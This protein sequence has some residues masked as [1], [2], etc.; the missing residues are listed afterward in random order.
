MAYFRCEIGT[1]EEVVKNG[2]VVS[3]KT[4]EADIEPNTFVEITKRAEGGLTETQHSLLSTLSISAA[5]GNTIYVID[6]LEVDE[7]NVLIAYTAQQNSG[8]GAVGD[9]NSYYY[10]AARVALLTK[11]TSGYTVTQSADITNISSMYGLKLLY[12][13]RRQT[14]WLIYGKNKCYSND[15]DLT[16]EDAN[17]GYRE[18]SINVS[19]SSISLGT[20]GVIRYANTVYRPD[21]AAEAITQNST[22]FF[23]VVFSEGKNGDDY[24]YTQSI[25]QLD[26]YPYNRAYKVSFS[27]EWNNRIS[28]IFYCGDGSSSSYYL[29]TLDYN[30]VVK[31][32]KVDF[33]SYGSWSTIENL[34]LPN[35]P[36]MK[37][38]NY[39]IIITKENGIVCAKYYTIACDSLGN[40]TAT[41]EKTLP[42]GYSYPTYIGK[43]NSDNRIVCATRKGMFEWQIQIYEIKNSEW[44]L[45]GEKAF[46]FGAW[47]TNTT[48]PRTY[49]NYTISE[50]TVGTLV[51]CVAL[52]NAKISG[53]TKTKCTA[54][55][56][57]EVWV[58]N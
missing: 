37:I 14:Y 6:A 39:D 35:V 42:I 26:V 21:F 51:D 41:L 47:I 18:I 19:S 40:L 31:L 7:N 48:V 13:E 57:G 50:Y 24:I 46:S 16:N 5:T 4:A 23:I 44:A 17:M 11:T 52:P 53:I 8:G 33:S 22:S 36:V 10:Y 32:C 27:T 25:I 38:D 28:D 54:A 1:N 12:H 34:D 30:D 43:A 45:L 3:Y 9:S 49:A 20:E 15:Y 58:L 56:A 55:A 29:M 2:K